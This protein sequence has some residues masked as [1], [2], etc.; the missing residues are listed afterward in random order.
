M[1]KLLWCQTW[2]NLTDSL[3]LLTKTVKD[4]WQKGQ[5]TST[6]FLDVKG[7]FPSVDIKQLFH[8]MQKH[9]IPKEYI[10]WMKR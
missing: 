6:L 5:V 10:H 7:A 2:M 1:S 8:N 9:G 3:H 4:T